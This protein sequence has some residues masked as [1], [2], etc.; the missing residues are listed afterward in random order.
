MKSGAQIPP[1][2]IGVEDTTENNAT[3]DDQ[4]NDNAKDMATTVTSSHIKTSFP[5][6]ASPAPPFLTSGK[7][8]ILIEN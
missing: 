3:D 2:T 1:L 5:S 8:V 4:D 6:T 7:T